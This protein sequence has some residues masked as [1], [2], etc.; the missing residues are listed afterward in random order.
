MEILE[1]EIIPTYYNDQEKWVNIM[2]NSMNDVACEFDS[3]SMAD[4]YYKK[5]YTI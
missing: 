3:D 4:K 2:K 5:M 1:N